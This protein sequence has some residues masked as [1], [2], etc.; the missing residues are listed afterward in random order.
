MMKYP[1]TDE[2]DDARGPGAQHPDL[3]LKGEQ[4]HPL[5]LWPL[6]PEVDDTLDDEA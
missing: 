2:H 3:V 4:E 6:E 1:K 5:L